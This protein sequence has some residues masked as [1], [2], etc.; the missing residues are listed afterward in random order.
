[1]L[2]TQPIQARIL[3]AAPPGSNGRDLAF[4]SL[5]A[6]YRAHGG[7]VRAEALAACMGAAGCGGY[8][9][10]ARRI[11]AGQLFSFQWHDAIWLPL[12]QLDPRSLAPRD[13]TRQVM[14][15]LRGAF[16]GWGLAHW[17][18]LPHAA[19]AGCTPLDRLTD[20]LPAVLAA[21]RGDRARCAEAAADLGN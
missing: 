15:E 8:V 9:D 19:L 12:F 2:M 20:D 5:Q 21:A 18:V 10:L 7:L 4:M 13:A 17:Y 3:W 16:D 14:D 1:M 11:V 6:A